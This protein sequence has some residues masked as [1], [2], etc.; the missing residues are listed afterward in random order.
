[1]G[2]SNQKLHAIMISF[3]FQGHITP[4]VHLAIKL[5]SK[6]F[7]ITFV[8]TEFIHHQITKSQPHKTIEPQVFSEARKSGLDIRYTTITDGL[9]LE[10]DR[11]SNMKQYWDSI[12]QVFPTHIDEFV[13]NMVKSHPLSAFFLVTDT[14]YAWPATIAKKYNFV[15]VSFWTQPALIF[16]LYYHLDLLIKN[17]HFAS[18]DNRMDTIAYIPGVKA[19]EPKDLTSTLQET[20]TT[21]L[22]H[23]V[24]FKAFEE[25]KKADIVICNTVEEL[26][27]ETISALHQ[28]SPIY[29]IGPIFPPRFT[30]STVG[31]SLRAAS[32]CTEWLNT[33]PHGSVLYVAFGSLVRISEHDM[34]E[35]AHG[36]LLS[37]ANFIW[38]LRPG[39]IGSDGTNILPVGFEDSIKDRGMIVPWCN[40]IEVLSHSAVGGFLTHCGWNSLFESIWFGVP[41]ICF[42][43]AYDQITNRK[44]VVNDW[45][46]G[47]NL[48]DEKSITRGEVGEK[49]NLLMRGTKSDELRKEMN[50]V[51][52]TLE[53]ALATDGSSEKNF[54]QFIKNVKELM[55]KRNGLSI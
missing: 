16:T 53:N 50:R 23:R 14:L 15:I 18:N 42:P 19:I 48:R 38:V 17:G 2:D 44:L 11:S 5:A 22:V 52:K 41:L 26:E 7:T 12:M 4:F 25:V 8:H 20:D 9:P 1:M 33:K 31:T 55:R 36:L 34:A 47:I 54:K 30:K 6:G 49:I 32:D 13:N 51:K 24:T 43:F 39:T 21:T 37:E 29:A 3:P 40:Q 27:S 35:I 28:K 10:F 46:I 45:K